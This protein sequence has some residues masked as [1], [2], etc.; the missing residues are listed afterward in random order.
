MAHTHS[1]FDGTRISSFSQENFS[2]FTTMAAP[3]PRLFEGLGQDMNLNP[4]NSNILSISFWNLL[5]LVS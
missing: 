3:P 1:N 4:F 5:F 2:V